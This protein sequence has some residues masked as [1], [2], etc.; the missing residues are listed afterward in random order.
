MTVKWFVFFLMVMQVGG[1]SKNFGHI[2][3]WGGHMK[4]QNFLGSFVIIK[5]GMSYPFFHVKGKNEQ[6]NPGNALTDNTPYIL[7]GL[8]T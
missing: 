4:L 8:I 5:G 6:I 2:C 1:H 7:L 3:W